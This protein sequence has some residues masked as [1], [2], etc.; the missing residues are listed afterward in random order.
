[1]KKLEEFAKCY[2]FVFSN[3]CLEKLKNYN[4]FFR[5]IIIKA[6]CSHFVCGKCLLDY[7]MYKSDYRFQ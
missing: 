7:I 4:I 5:K 1:M 3:E 6:S 2:H